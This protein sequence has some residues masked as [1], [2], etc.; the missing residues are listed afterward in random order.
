MPTIDSDDAAMLR[1]IIHGLQGSG[2]PTDEDTRRDE[3]VQ[4]WADSAA[5]AK[6]L[7]DTAQLAL[8]A[9]TAPT[10]FLEEHELAMSLPNDAVRTDAERAGRMVAMLALAGGWTQERIIEALNQLGVTAAV[11]LIVNDA[12]TIGFGGWVEAA[13]TYAIKLSATDYADKALRRGIATVFGRMAPAHSVGQHGNQDPSSVI[14]TSYGARWGT[15]TGVDGEDAYIGRACIYKTTPSTADPG[16]WGARRWPVSVP[17]TLT[18]EMLNDLQ[19]RLLWGASPLDGGWSGHDLEGHCEFVSGTCPVSSSRDLTDGSV[20]YTDRLVIV[21]GVIRTGFDVRPGGASEN[22]TQAAQFNRL[23]YTGDGSTAY[24]TAISGIGLLRIDG[25]IVQIVENAAAGD[26]YYNLCLQTTGAVGGRSSPTA[27]PVG[28]RAIDFEDGDSLTTLP[29]TFADLLYDA[30]AWKAAAESSVGMNVV[31]GGVRRC[32]AAINLERPASG[33]EV[34]VLDTT[35][36]WRDRF[37]AI[38]AIVWDST[39]GV[40]PGQSD[41][42]QTYNFFDRWHMYTGAGD[43]GDGSSKWEGEFDDANDLYIFAR[44]TDGALCCMI[45]DTGAADILSFAFL[46]SATVQ[47]DEAVTPTEDEPELPAPS[48]GDLVDPKSLWL[49]QDVGF[50]QQGAEGRPGDMSYQ[51]SAAN[52][53]PAASESMA[54]GPVLFGDPPLPA[55]IEVPVS[56]YEGKLHRTWR[57]YVQ[58]QNVADSLR[59]FQCIEIEDDETLRIA[60]SMVDGVVQHDWRDRVA[61]VASAWSTTDLRPGAGA[62]DDA[63]INISSAQTKR[64]WYTGAGDDASDAETSDQYL[65]TLVDHLHLFVDEDNGLLKL[66]NTTGSTYYV[67]LMIEA[68]PQFGTRGRS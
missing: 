57:N 5:W 51:V 34:R 43:P 16:K 28:N 55:T 39:H 67:V 65:C 13:H 14:V 49:P 27:A 30:N 29:T 35:Q 4:V 31:A 45:E 47:L 38:D 21:S 66:E 36:D 52:T 61:Y 26:V 17:T 2:Y 62:S 54:M 46:I 56:Y 41:D 42:D 11:E 50:F 15:A 60:G 24:D 6:G 10:L 22:G 23:W 64:T 53:Q 59:A 48:T 25:G 20:D 1:R 18:A 40:W 37:L 63:G 32:C 9:Q 7:I 12:D 68:G 44:S 3:L 58:R 8:L 33:Y 19:E